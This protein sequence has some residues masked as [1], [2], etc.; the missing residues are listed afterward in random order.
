MLQTC[1]ILLVPHKVVAALRLDDTLIDSSYI[2]RTHGVHR[3]ARYCSSLIA[4]AE[5][6]ITLKAALQAVSK[7]PP[8]SLM[9]HARDLCQANLAIAEA[10]VFIRQSNSYHN[11]RVEAEVEAE[12]TVVPEDTGISYV[13][14]RDREVKVIQ[15]THDML[16][17]HTSWRERSENVVMKLAQHWVYVKLTGSSSR[18]FSDADEHRLLVDLRHAVVSSTPAVFTLLRGIKRKRSANGL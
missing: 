9:L 13:Q 10:F 12:H 17:S 15:E 14:T 16:Q 6:L 1:L 18:A 4:M 11:T 2:P 8:Q 5:D 3:E 7:A